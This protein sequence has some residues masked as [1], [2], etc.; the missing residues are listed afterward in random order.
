[1]SRGQ[2]SA[3]RVLAAAG[4]RTKHAAVRGAL[5]SGLLDALVTDAAAA[6]HALRDRS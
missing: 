6:R 4:G 1:M 2:L 3:T 5:C